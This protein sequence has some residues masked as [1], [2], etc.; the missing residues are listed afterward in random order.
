M[1]LGGRRCQRTLLFLLFVCLRCKLSF[2]SSFILALQ[3]RF[4]SFPCTLLPFIYMFRPYTISL[5]SLYFIFRFLL[6]FCY[7]NFLSSYFTL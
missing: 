5:Q 6:F 4:I 3:I 7:P 1:D 2:A